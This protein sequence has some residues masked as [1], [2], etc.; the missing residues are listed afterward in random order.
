LKGP[1]LF[2]ESTLNNDV[3]LASTVDGEKLMKVV[4][5]DNLHHGSSLE[6]GFV[7]RAYLLVLPGYCVSLMFVKN[8]GNQSKPSED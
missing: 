4:A 7:R 2:R 8:D 5:V 1:G 3:S 6:R